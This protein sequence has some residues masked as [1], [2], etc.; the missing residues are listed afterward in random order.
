MLICSAFGSCPSLQGFIQK[1][2]IPQKGDVQRFAPACFLVS[3]EFQF[4]AIKLAKTGGSTLLK[5][6]K[7]FLCGVTFRGSYDK[8]KACSSTWLLDHGQ[9]RGVPDDC[10]HELPSPHIWKQYFVFV[11]VRDPMARRRSMVDYCRIGLNDSWCDSCSAT[12]EKCGRCSPW[13]CAPMAGTVISQDGRSFVDYVAY[14]ETLNEDMLAIFSHINRLQER[15]KARPM[16]FSSR[17]AATLKTNPSTGK[18]H[19]AGGECPETNC[20]KHYADDARLFGSCDFNVTYS[21]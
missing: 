10:L 13:H 1:G 7:E 6:L 18:A 19:I 14:T 11:I 4:I 16:N 17:V 8:D 9:G 5:F 12:P 15:R 20:L 21:W 2:A 3:H